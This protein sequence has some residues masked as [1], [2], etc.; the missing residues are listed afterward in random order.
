MPKLTDSQLVILS[1][2]AKHEDHAVLPLPKSLK[3]NKGAAASVLKSLL[4]RGLIAERPATRDDEVWHEAEDGQ[5][6]ALIATDLGLAAVGADPDVKA[7]PPASKP[8][9]KPREGSAKRTPAGSKA[10][11]E[12]AKPAARPGTK[13]ALLIDLLGRK[14]G[15][16]IDEA[17][18]ATGWQLHS[19]RG[20]I[21]GALKKKLGL[22]IENEAID[23]RGRVYRIA[24]RG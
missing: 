22:A 17:A 15:A 10:S 2:A 19:V 13:L 20:A 14:G 1:A 6:I 5:K 7:Q 18:K 12:P 16:T 24:T 3:I 23:G 8:Q 4:K 21:S 9:R 11:R